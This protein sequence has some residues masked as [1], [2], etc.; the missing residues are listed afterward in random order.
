MPLS[1]KEMIRLLKKHGYVEVSQ[2]GSHIKLVQKNSGNT[3]I[4]PY[5]CKDL[6]K[7]LEQAIL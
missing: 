3:V 7:G 4:V 1:S 2:N 5:H 6:M